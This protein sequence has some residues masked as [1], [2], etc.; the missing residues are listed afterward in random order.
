MSNEGAARTTWKL[1]PIKTPNDLRRFVNCHDYGVQWLLPPVREE[2][3]PIRRTMAIITDDLPYIDWE[4]PNLVSSYLDS[5][6]QPLDELEALGYGLFALIRVR[7]R[8]FPDG[9][10]MLWRSLVLVVAPTPC[11]YAEAKVDENGRTP[12]HILNG[13]SPGVENI[14]KD[15]MP[16]LIVFREES[17]N[18]EWFDSPELWCTECWKGVEVLSESLKSKFGSPEG[19]KADLRL[20]LA[21]IAARLRAGVPVEGSEFELKARYSGEEKFNVLKAVAAFRNGS[22]GVVILGMG[23]DGSV[24]GIGPILAAEGYSDIDS[25]C[26]AL[27]AKIDAD[28]SPSPH[29]EVVITVVPLADTHVCRIDVLA[30]DAPEIT[31]LAQ[32]IYLRVGSESR[33]LEGR[34]LAEWLSKRGSVTKL[35]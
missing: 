13:C 10:D 32:Q 25:L 17:V 35:T 8:L 22:G 2:E 18:A 33:K 14:V 20:D 12:L 7:W 29:N 26:L 4:E 3:R 19:R 16:T 27:H 11:I 6:D 30:L 5:I 9:S 1:Q 34:Q 28:L 24:P 21:L 23:N 31:F 15:E